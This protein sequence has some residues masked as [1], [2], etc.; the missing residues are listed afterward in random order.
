[1]ASFS[2][3]VSRLP[4]MIT[5]SHFIIP[6]LELQGIKSVCVDMG[7]WAVLPTS[8]RTQSQRP[9]QREVL[10][11]VGQVKSLGVVKCLEV[12]LRLLMQFKIAGCVFAY[13]TFLKEK[14]PTWLFKNIWSVLAQILPEYGAFSSTYIV[15]PA[16]HVIQS[17]P[18]VLGTRLGLSSLVFLSSSPS[19]PWSC[20]TK[21]LL[22]GNIGLSS[23]SKHFQEKTWKS[24][25][26]VSTP[27]CPLCCHLVWL[28]V[29][30]PTLL[31]IQFISGLDYYCIYLSKHML[32]HLLTSP[33]LLFYLILHFDKIEIFVTF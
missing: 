24:I 1:M 29:K 20:H 17:S 30:P 10:Q 31:L 26:S 16:G 25:F 22:S 33:C 6:G 3:Y 19:P 13:S 18:R 32:N 8:P 9:C 4:L 7:S 27:L 5:G 21:T 15:L 14:S 2:L 11:F 23:K 28:V 12:S